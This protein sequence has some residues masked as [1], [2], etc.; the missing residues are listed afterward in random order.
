MFARSAYLEIRSL[1]LAATQ[2]CSCINMLT[3]R[4]GFSLESKACAMSIPA[5]PPKKNR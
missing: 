2:P 3:F 5:P 1:A 4:I